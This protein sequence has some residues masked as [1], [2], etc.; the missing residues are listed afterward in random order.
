VYSLGDSRYMPMKVRTN[1]TRL[2]TKNSVDST[3]SSLAATWSSL[4]FSASYAQPES[5]RSCSPSENSA[6]MAK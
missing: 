4:D 6:R 3:G 5:I 1:E 2:H